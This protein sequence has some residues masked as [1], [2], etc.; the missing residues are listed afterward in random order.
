MS[1][2]TALRRFREA[3]ATAEITVTVWPVTVRL[4]APPAPQRPESPLVNGHIR[5]QRRRHGERNA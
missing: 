1:L 3:M 4:V 5:A 2:R